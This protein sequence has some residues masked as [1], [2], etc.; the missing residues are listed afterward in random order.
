[1]KRFF[2]HIIGNSTYFPL[3]H[4]IS[5]A[6][7]LLS[8]LFGIQS[9][10]GNIML[11]LP[12]ITIYSSAVAGLLLFLFYYLSRFKNKREIAVTLALS[13]SV[14]FYI[15]IM[16]IGNGGSTG[17][18][19]YY[20]FLYGAFTMSALDGKKAII[21]IFLFLVVSFVLYILEYNNQITIYDYNTPF[22]RLADILISFVFVLLGISA[23]IHIYKTQYQKSNNLLAEKN[24]KLNQLIE[25]ITSQRDEI[26]T[27]RDEIATQR[28]RVAEQN[29][30]ITI[31][32]ENIKDS[33]NYAK[34]IQNAV[35]PEKEL[36]TQIFK[37]HFIIYKPK[38]VVSG[39]FYWVTEI[40]NYKIAVV[41]DCTGHGVPGGFMSMLGVSFLN[42]IIN[43]NKGFDAANILNELRKYTIDALKQHGNVGEQ[44]DGMDLS[45]CVV[46]KN[47]KEL[48]YAGA[49]NSIYIVSKN[50]L[51]EQNKDRIREY[52]CTE[53]DIKNKLYQVLPD[54]MPI[55]YYV[56]MNNFNNIKIKLQPNDCV[57]MFSD[58][59]ADQFGGNKGRKLGYKRLRK[60]ILKNS[61][62]DLTEQHTLFID[63]L[64]DWQG[65]YEQIDDIT[66][67]AFKC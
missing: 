65:N 42:E 57:Y 60:T 22:D 15:P 50:N 31:Q 11:N 43:K 45:I 53:N 21:F 40:D 54:K 67:F 33:I 13:L 5:N 56:K 66:V 32:N 29:E 59:Y 3:N 35:L 14:L 24:I 41:S 2:A 61:Y 10:V 46:N 48:D 9:T 38:D 8:V 19:V 39:D 55:S 28:D 51:L 52:E 47:T 12:I 23:T 1:M 6:I 30:I 7:L 25:E 26:E 17:G 49:N 4:R 64:N 16:W 37:N 63:T 44:S 20:I 27:Q 58:G 18:M 34:K 62:K 36:I